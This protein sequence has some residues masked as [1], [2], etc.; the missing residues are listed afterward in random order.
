MDT[1]I[2]K[3]EQT[4]EETA[5][6]RREAACQNENLFFE[7]S[8]VMGSPEMLK[9][10]VEWFRRL[11]IPCAIAKTDGGYTLWRKGEE[12]GRKTSEVPPVLINKNIVYSFCLAGREPNLLKQRQREGAGDGRFQS[13]GGFEDVALPGWEEERERINSTL[14]LRSLQGKE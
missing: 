13:S 3:K 10:W 14:P 6:N 2:N 4:R 8:K 9:S 1:D 7:M 5:R 12:V 11:H